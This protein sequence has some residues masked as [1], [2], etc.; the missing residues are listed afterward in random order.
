MINISFR[1]GISWQVSCKGIPSLEKRSVDEQGQDGGV[2]GLKLTFY[3]KNT[4]LQWTAEQ[5]LT[6]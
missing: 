4:E 5:P 1:R 2:E 6:K 3:H